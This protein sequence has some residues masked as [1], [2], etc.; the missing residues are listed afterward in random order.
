MLKL[1]NEY[2]E[3][4]SMNPTYPFVNPQPLVGTTQ[5]VYRF[6]CQHAHEKGFAPSYREI[7]EACQIGLSSVRWHLDKLETEGYIQRQ[8]GIARGIR[9][10]I[11]PD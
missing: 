1:L 9:L 2:T 7:G 6:M 10:L 4:L 3:T 8:L 5:V 11:T